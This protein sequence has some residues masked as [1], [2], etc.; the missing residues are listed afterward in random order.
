M[1]KTPMMQDLMRKDADT[2]ALNLKDQKHFN[3]KK[4]KKRSDQIFLYILLGVI[5]L[6]LLSPFL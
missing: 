3:V 6:I 4:R 2:Q 5:A 1:F